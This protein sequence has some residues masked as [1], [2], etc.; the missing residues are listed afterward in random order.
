MASDMDL[1]KTD[2]I[3]RLFDAL[4]ITSMVDLNGVI[5]TTDI[6]TGSSIIS[7]QLSV[8]DTTSDEENNIDSTSFPN[9]LPTNSTPPQ[10]NEKSNIEQNSEI[11]PEIESLNTLVKD[12][13]TLQRALILEKRALM[14]RGTFIPLLK[15]EIKE[16]K[17]GKS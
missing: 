3:K 16:T 12:E 4:D 5:F 14:T 10:F 13:P 2:S 8:R 1:L 15:F 6:E 11:L 7:Q 9:L 17:E